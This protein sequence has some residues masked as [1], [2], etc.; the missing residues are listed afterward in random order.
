MYQRQAA[1]ILK[2]GM[3]K[4]IGKIATWNSER[5]FGF[6]EHDGGAD[7]F[8]HCS[9]L[10]DRSRDHLPVGTRVSFD[11]APPARS[12]KPRAI[13]VTALTGN[14]ALPRPSPREAAQAHFRD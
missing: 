6:V 3:T 1:L 9:D 11:I 14:T 5:G 10:S 13:N 12:G 7:I 2:L 8:V 4:M